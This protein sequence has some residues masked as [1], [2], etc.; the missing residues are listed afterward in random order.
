MA[1]INGKFREKLPS[2]PRSLSDEELAD[3]FGR[4][5]EESRRRGVFRKEIIRRNVSELIGEEFE[6][7]ISHKG[8]K[9]FDHDRCR[10]LLGEKVYEKLWGKALT[11]WVQA[12]RIKSKRKTNPRALGTNPRALGVNPRALGVNPRN[13]KRHQN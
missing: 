11:K 3:K 9:K 1:R 12:T 6:V 5:S 4:T 10:E 2:G 7:R 8:M 13:F